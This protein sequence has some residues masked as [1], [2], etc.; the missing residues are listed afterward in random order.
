MTNVR[1]LALFT[2]KLLKGE[3]LQ[4]ESSL[5]AMTGDGTTDYRLGL[6]CADLEGRLAWG[7]TGFWNT[8]VFHVPSLDLTV[9]GCILNHFAT[10][11][12]TL[13]E[14]LVDRVVE[15]CPE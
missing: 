2:R 8:F 9:S 3:V 4:Q 14:K 15:S 1:D 5:A 11:G 13:A 7:H 12:Q 6:I 10:K